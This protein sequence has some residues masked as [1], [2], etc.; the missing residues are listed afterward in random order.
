MSRC[1]RKHLWP[2]C[3]WMKKNNHLP[4]DARLAMTMSDLL[5]GL[6]DAQR[7]AVSAPPGPTLVIAGPGSGKT[8]VLTRRVAYLTREIGVPPL[9]IITVTFANKAANENVERIQ[10][11]PCTDMCG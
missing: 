2:S 8:A 4:L 7:E 1:R 3:A 11:M 9:K 5:V 10:K 6:N